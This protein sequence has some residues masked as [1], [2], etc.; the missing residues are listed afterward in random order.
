VRKRAGV[1]LSHPRI[2][3]LL[4][5]TSQPAARTFKALLIHWDGTSWSLAPCPNPNTGS[6][7]TN[8]LWG[9][10]VTG[11]GNVWIVGAAETGIQ[12]PVLHTAGG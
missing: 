12:A 11:P 2:C 5:R 4:A 9:G 6:V 3:G 10:V 8:I 1:W 7:Q